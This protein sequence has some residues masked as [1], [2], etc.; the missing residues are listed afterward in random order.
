MK[1]DTDRFR[2]AKT[3]NMRLRPFHLTRLIGSVLVAGYRFVWPQLDWW[4]NGPFNDY[5]AQFGELK[6]MNTQRRW[7]LYQLQR[8]TASVPG[9][10]A[11]CGVYTGAG[12]YSILKVNEASGLK[13]T[14]MVFDSFAGLSDPSVEDGAHWEGG[15]LSCSL[16]IVKENLHEFDD[17]LYFKGWIPTRFAEV[18]GRRFSF[19]HIDVDLYEPT[20]NSFA[21]LYER[22]NPGGIIVRDDY[23]FSTCPGATR[24]IDE[25]LEDKK[26]KMISLSGGGGFVIKGTETAGALF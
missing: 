18:A 10:T 6:G 7:A 20:R 11:E 23:G 13:K 21:F 9:D 24:A 4:K 26:E 15:D 2:F 22:L 1:L 12:S 14:H 3:R 19:V 17:V 16:E 25:H 5:L 8:L